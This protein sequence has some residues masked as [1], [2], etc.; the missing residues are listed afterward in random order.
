MNSPSYMS[1]SSHRTTCRARAERGN[2]CRHVGGGWRWWVEVVAGGGGLVKLEVVDVVSGW[3]EL[4][5]RWMEATRRRWEA[6]RVRRRAVPTLCQAFEPVDNLIG[7][8]EAVPLL[9]GLALEVWPPAR[10][11]PVVCAVDS[12]HRMLLRLEHGA[13][14]PVGHTVH[15]A[16]AKRA[17]GIGGRAER[18]EGGPH[19]LRGRRDMRR[20]GAQL[21]SLS[22]RALGA[23]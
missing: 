18:A 14:V 23:G 4:A 2:D 9:D 19:A 13:Y 8:E 20:A 16:E 1:T 7:D 21:G 15:L 11:L 5:G 17:G 22:D 10:A 3:V 6:S 12:D